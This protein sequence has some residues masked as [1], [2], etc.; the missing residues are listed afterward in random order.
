MNGIRIDIG[1]RIVQIS[2][3]R[4]YGFIVHHRRFERLRHSIPNTSANPPQTSISTKLTNETKIENSQNAVPTK[5]NF[6]IG[7]YLHIIILVLIR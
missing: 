6:S 1:K 4:R 7:L 2:V 3:R 5:I